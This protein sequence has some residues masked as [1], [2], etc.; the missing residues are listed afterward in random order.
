MKAKKTVAEQK[1]VTGTNDIQ[2]QHLTLSVADGTSM[3]AY[4]ARPAGPGVSP[5]ILVF[6]E[7]FGV[8][9]HIREVAERFAR[10][11]Y[12]AIAPALYHRTDPQFEC[13]YSDSSVYRPH[14]K[15]I[16]EVGMEADVK[17]AFQ[18]VTAPDGGQVQKVVSVGY[19]LGGRVSFLAD[20]VLPLHGAV[21]Y[22]GG[23]IGPGPGQTAPPLLSR[24]KDLHA[25][26]LLFWGGLD[27]HIGKDTTRAVADALLAAGKNFTEVTFSKAD[28]G[29]FCDARASY[30]PNAARQSWALTLAF[31][32]SLLQ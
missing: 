16:T 11:G 3:P 27:S 20:S 22:Y 29:F 14:M 12:V 2:C 9:P 21:S 7:A 26:L 1:D 32:E 25:P 15:A 8:N 23:G 28:H 17:A 10:A 4:V 13:G 5:G 24:G 31:F 19:C 30:E 6:Q 18:W